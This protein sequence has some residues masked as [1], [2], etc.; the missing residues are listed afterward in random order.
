MFCAKF[1]LKFRLISIIGIGAGG[2][3]NFLGQIPFPR[4][5]WVV[6][7]RLPLR[8]V[9]RLFQDMQREQSTIMN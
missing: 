4:M 3:I 6:Q 1:T 5:P 9:P 8:K 7:Y 2:T